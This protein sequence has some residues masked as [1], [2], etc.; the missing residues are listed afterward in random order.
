M[1]QPLERARIKLRETEKDLRLSHEH[2]VSGYYY[3]RPLA[4]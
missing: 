3:K 4:C 2:S 1:R